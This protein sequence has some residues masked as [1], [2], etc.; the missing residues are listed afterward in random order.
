MT[1]AHSA[2]GHD[3]H[4]VEH[5]GFP[6][7]G[8]G[9]LRGAGGAC[10]GSRWTTKIGFFKKCIKF[11]RMIRHLLFL[12]TRERCAEHVVVLLGLCGKLYGGDLLFPAECI[13]DSLLYTNHAAAR[14]K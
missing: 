12:H 4:L 10:G 7:V 3:E 6:K 11:K 8:S 5:E 2:S 9:N 14:I 13:K 1:P